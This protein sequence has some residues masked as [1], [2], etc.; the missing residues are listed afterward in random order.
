MGPYFLITVCYILMATE[1]ISLA[2][3]GFCS[4]KPTDDC[5]TQNPVDGKRY[6]F[7]NV[8]PSEGFNLRRD[9]YMRLAVFMNKWKNKHSEWYLVLP[10]WNHLYHWHS[11]VYQDHLP[12]RLFFDVESMK[13]FA[14]VIELDELE[15]EVGNVDEVYYLEHFKD[16]FSRK[17]WDWTD[18]YSIVP[19]NETDHG[20]KIVDGIYHSQ[21]WGYDIRAKELKCTSFQGGASLLGDVLSKTPNKNIMID[22]AEV[23]LH[24]RFGDKS[25]WDCRRSMRFA[26]HLVAEANDF[27]RARLSSSDE[28]DDTDIPAMWEDQKNVER[29]ERGGA[30]ICAHLRR[31]D[32]MHSRRNEIPT[33]ASAAE[34]LIEVLTNLNLSTVFLCTDGSD[35]EILEL[36][37]LLK[38]YELVTYEPSSDQLNKFKDGGVAIIDQL[39]CSNARYFIG[40]HESTFSFRIQ[41]EREIRGF[42]V[43]HTFN[44]FCG[45]NK[46]CEQPSKW[47]IVF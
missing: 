32:F 12:W 42:P 41:D 47:K 35:E 44:R 33:I 20:Y 21:M 45:S 28:A 10:P 38:G 4:I 5:S 37:K 2:D 34:Q 9:V 6:L 43:E 36:K 22:R 19:C 17:D 13:R 24:D 31:G 7:Y 16:A 25:Y 18:R 1:R 29:K 26:D 3:D 27:R 14:P 11:D 46:D 15:E 39:I 23:V 8:N 40:S 30:Y